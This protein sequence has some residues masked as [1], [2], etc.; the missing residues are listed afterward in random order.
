[1]KK[2]LLYLSIFLIILGIAFRNILLDFSASLIDW[3]DYALMVWTITQNAHKILSLNF[4]NFFTANTFYPNTNTLFFSDLLLPQTILSLP[5]FI[6]NKNPV[7][8]FNF[9]F[10]ITFILNYVSSYLLFNKIF[11]NNLISFLASLFLIF[12]PFFYLELGHFQMMSY[13]PGLFCLYFIFKSEEKNKI[14]NLIFAGIFISLQFL[15]SVYLSIFFIFAVFIFYFTKFIFQ[16]NISKI[17]KSLTIIFITFIILGGGFIYGYTYTKN[18]YSF[19]RDPNEYIFYSAHFSDYLFTNQIN[20]IIHKSPL[21][22]KWNS[23]NKNVSGGHATF[24]GFTLAILSLLSLLKIYKEKGL[25]KIKI[26]L[27]E[28]RF[29]FLSLVLI[30][31]IFSLGPRLNFNGNY[32]HIPLPYWILMKTVPFLESIRAL[33][34][35]SFLFYLGIVGLAFE[36][37]KEK[38]NI[39][40]LGIIFILFF[41]EYFPFNIKAYKDT[42]V[43]EGTKILKSACQKEKRVVL[44][45]PITHFDGT[46][47]IIGGLTYISKVQLASSYHNC[48]L[49]NG[50]SGYDL[51]SLLKFK[52][53]FYQIL[54][55]KNSDKLLLFLRQ[56]KIDILQV[57]RER[58]DKESLSNYEVVYSQ[59]L[60]KDIKI[61][62]PNIFEI[63]A[64]K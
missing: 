57:N 55:T 13:W 14:K 47:G 42:Y 31:F 9:V 28:Q 29:F 20:S 18:Q 44:E 58:L 12:S 25:I 11:K 53:D 24:P 23:F 36:Y 2:F 34:R 33:C 32:V 45:V 3:R 5:L 19:K 4:V 50:Y 40:L 21:I 64:K 60:K 39:F 15:A 59:I 61:L 1:M 48:Y 17:I 37:L 35:W 56:N 38:K 26:E 41:L 54:S 8:I 16:K 63:D 43:D 6:I 49:I 52:D 46:G 30:G 10:I 51:P 22:N 7:L 27:N 62:G